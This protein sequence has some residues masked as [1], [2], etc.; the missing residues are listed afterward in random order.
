MNALHDAAGGRSYSW[1]HEVVIGVSLILVLLVAGWLVPGF[2]KPESQ[3]LLSRQLWEFSILA[4]GMTLIIIT[5]GIDL[6]VGSTMGLS[7]VAFGGVH[8]VSGSLFAAGLACLATGLIC[9][10]VNGALIAGL[11]LHPLIVTLATFAAYRGIA[12][13]W[14]QGCSYSRF[15]D[16]FSDFARDSWF[17]VPVPGA[18]FCLMAIAFSIF[19]SRTPDGR[20]LYA[21]GHN[22]RAAK[23]SG[24]A[25]DRIRFWLYTTSGL[26]AGLASLIYVARFDTAKADVG[27]GFELDVI[28]A[29]VLGGTSIYG[30]RGSILGTTLGLLLIHETKLFVSRYWGSDE[31][32][33]IVI[34]CLL[35]VAVLACQMVL[36]KRRH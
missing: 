18:I 34:G 25:V 32:R 21:I 1:W 9:G 36:R 27:K 8:E 22:E 35:I 24:I 2:L 19:L 33:S 7:A 15:G 31:L 28:T 14:S 3:L 10:A 20:F 26:L 4:L 5:G 17:G 23:F 16:D 13:G 29:V 12:E 11:R 30:G 6:S